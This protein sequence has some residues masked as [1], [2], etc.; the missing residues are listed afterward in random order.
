MNVVFVVHFVEAYLTNIE[1]VPASSLERN[2]FSL[3]LQNVFYR[4]HNLKQCFPGHIDKYNRLRGFFGDFN[5]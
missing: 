4:M 3:A 5:P 2:T 1:I